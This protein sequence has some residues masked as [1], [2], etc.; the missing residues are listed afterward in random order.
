MIPV[1]IFILAIIGAYL[2]AIDAAF[3]ALIRLSVRPSLRYSLFAS[4]V[5]FTN[6]NT[7]IELTFPAPADLCRINRTA[8][9]AI[10]RA[11]T[12]PATRYFE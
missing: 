3:S 12:I 5:A 7:A 4:D 1:G 11:A 8:A 2:G 6:G 10:R 9:P